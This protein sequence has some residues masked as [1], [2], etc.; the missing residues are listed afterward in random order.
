MVRIYVLTCLTIFS[1]IG[2]PA[3]A[4]LRKAGIRVHILKTIN[5]AHLQVLEVHPWHQPLQD[6]ST[7]PSKSF[8]IKGI[9]GS[10]EHR[11]GGGCLRHVGEVREVGVLG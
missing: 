11:N 2:A 4:E 6:L 3:G 7:Q 9:E 5:C 1:T 8:D 10:S